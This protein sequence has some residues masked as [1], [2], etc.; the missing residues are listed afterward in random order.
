MF[1]MTNEELIKR[2]E[3]L[4]LENSELKNKHTHEDTK[5][6]DLHVLSRNIDTILHSNPNHIFICNTAGQFT[7]VGPLAAQ[8]HGV[9]PHKILGKS[10]QDLDIPIDIA[11]HLENMRLD[12]ISQGQSVSDKTELPGSDGIKTFEYVMA[13]LQAAEYKENYSVICIAK[14][15]TDRIRIHELESQIKQELEGKVEGQTAGL[16]KINNLL[17][18]EIIE[19]RKSEQALRDK[20]EQLQTIINMIPNL[21]A[22]IDKNKCYQFNNKEFEKCFN[23]AVDDIQGK[24]VEQVVGEKRYSIIK[25]YI[26]Q[27]LLGNEVIFEEQIMCETGDLRWMRGHYY[28]DFDNTGKVSGFISLVIDFTEEKERQEKEKTRLIEHFHLARLGTIGE[29]ATEIAHE[30]N[31][32]LCAITNY[33]EAGLRMLELATGSTQDISE[34]LAEISI[35][36]N[37]AGK[38][39]ERLRSF[40][41]RREPKYEQLNVN[42]VIGEALH[43][44]QL[45]S[46]WDSIELR[47]EINENHPIIDADNL[48]VQQ[49]ILNLVRNARDAISSLPTPI[50]KITISSEELAEEYVNIMVSDSAGLL[51]GQ[52]LEKIFQP[53]YSTKNDGL[54]MGLA[55]SKTIVELHGGTMQATSNKDNET[56]VQFTLPTLHKSQLI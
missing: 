50:G 3:Q 42:A 9:E 36:S 31:Q 41:R 8:A 45:D 20:E 34:A 49:V 47:F 5:L 11:E 19:R 6:S 39:I 28:P 7:H 29:M 12:V 40:A 56:V 55:I 10:W 25:D 16:R 54:G 38:I 53:F 30:I 26:N 33:S 18:H 51:S 21:I 15:I 44:A 43:I 46:S 37:R 48:M 32:P 35:Q 22:Y 1:K 52:D 27:A 17:R 2:I 24:S 4:V 23:Q 14:D 13:P